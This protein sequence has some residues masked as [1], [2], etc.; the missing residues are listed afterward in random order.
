MKLGNRGGLSSLQSPQM[1]WGPQDR[2]K[3]AGTT[4]GYG[5]GNAVPLLPG[6]SGCRKQFLPP[7]QALEEGNEHQ[8]IF[9]KEL[10][11]KK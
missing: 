10:E 8:I 1:F 5:G 7:K 4:V 2:L 3:A 11:Q 9:S 6:F